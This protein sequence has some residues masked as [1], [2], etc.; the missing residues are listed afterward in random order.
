[1]YL[2]WRGAWSSPPSTHSHQPTRYSLH[3]CNKALPYQ[4]A[5]YG[6]RF[7]PPAACPQAQTT[8]HRQLAASS[9]LRRARR[10]DTARR[11][12]VPAPDASSTENA[13]AALVQASPYTYASA[14]PVDVVPARLQ[15]T[16]RQHNH[17]NRVRNRLLAGAGGAHGAH[18]A[19]RPRARQQ[20]SSPSRDAHRS[21][22]TCRSQISAQH[23][24]HTP[25]SRQKQRKKHPSPPPPK[26]AQPTAG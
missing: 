3:P 6:P 16:Q 10:P 11:T 22:P 21:R 2:L 18:H 7:C 25:A 1:M 8:A 4:S 14:A 19:D 20:Q 23:L 12:E 15:P 17:A 26:P 24:P 5:S 13:V 9:I